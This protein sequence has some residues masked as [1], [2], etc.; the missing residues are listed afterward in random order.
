MLVRFVICCLAFLLV[1]KPASADDAA[2][3]PSAARIVP[4]NAELEELWNEG[5]F[6]EG[7]AVSPDGTLYF[8]DIS[9]DETPGV[10][11]RFDPET[12]ETTVHCADSGKSNG[13]MFD[14]QGRLIAVCGANYG[15]QALCEITAD[16][17][18]REIVTAFEGKRFNAPN[19]VVVHPG[20]SIYFSDPRYIGPEPV[21]LDH[22][23]VYRYEPS[24]GALMRV[25]TEI[26][27]PNGVVVS[28]DGKTLYIAETNNQSLDVDNPPPEG[29]R[30]RMTLNAFPI[31]DDGSLG[32]R[33][34]LVNFGQQLGVDG[35][36]V[37]V[38]GHI[39]AAVR[40]AERFGIVVFTPDG[41][42]LAYIPTPDL[43]TN[44]C[45]GRGSEA[46]TL[47]VTAGIGLY[48]VR[49]NIPGYHPAMAE[50]ISR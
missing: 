8:S 40:S 28:P 15:Q 24:S 14:R 49:L 38:E 29:T 23:S 48:R 30:L 9:R 1:W 20:G 26:S 44:C 22:M 50:A 34:V 46:T 2:T 42:E 25:T 27:K 35:M 18:L 16:G 11:Y 19:D 37:D 32:E 39:Y 21:E 5:E 13:L 33:T 12:G 3:E 41:D 10:V 17:D 4:A 31:M 6:T 7:V 43:P 36:T 45:F 47:Y